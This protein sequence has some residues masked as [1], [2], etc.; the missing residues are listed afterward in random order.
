MNKLLAICLLVCSGSVLAES[1]NKFSTQ[2]LLLQCKSF[3]HYTE[4]PK[5]EL[6][7]ASVEELGKVNMCIGTIVGFMHA[8][9]AHNF[10]NK[11]VKGY[12]PIACLPESITPLQAMKV[13]VNYTDSHPEELHFHAAVVL[14]N[15]LA[16]TFPC[17]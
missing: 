7:N 13:F 11:D 1:D 15:S 10:Y 16:E 14:S 8:I 4:A 3:F 6:G 5:S 9:E 17:K 12:V 2:T